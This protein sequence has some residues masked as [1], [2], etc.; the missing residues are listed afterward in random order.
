[1]IALTLETYF[2]DNQDRESSKLD[3]NFV[4]CATHQ[5]RLFL[6]AGHDT[7]TSVLVYVYHMLHK[8][9]EV[10]SRMCE[11]HASIFGPDE[12]TVATM[13]RK[14]YALINQTPYTL[15][16][17]KETMRLY[18]PAGAFREGGPGVT[19]VNEQG[20]QFPTDGCLVSLVHHAIHLNPR[21]WPRA[22][23]FI[24]ERWLVEPGHELYPP[25]GAFR[26][27][28]QG[29]RNCIGQNLSLIELRVAL[30]M[31]VR[32]IRIKSA[33]EQWDTMKN[34]GPVGSLMAWVGLGKGV[35]RSINGERA[36]QIEKGG[37]HP[38]EGYPCTVELVHL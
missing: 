25:N 8:Y 14:N 18:S 5:I 10:L 29:P 22:Q 7:T 28:E 23:D 21:V 31:T 19:L 1:M 9:P 32:T 37:A 20:T 3:E 12:S 27:F 2:A 16:V 30:L 11:E 35:K 24:P 15:A 4:A 6:F 26:S 33:Y 36:Y 34:V 17:I 38:A 13:L